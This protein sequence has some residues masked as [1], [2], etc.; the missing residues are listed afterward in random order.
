MPTLLWW[1]AGLACLLLFVAIVILVIRFNQ[2]SLARD[3]CTE[4]HRQLRA[5]IHERRSLIPSFLESCTTLVEENPQL[6][7][8]VDAV[9]DAFAAARQS[10]G[11]EAVGAAEEQLTVALAQLHQR[12]GEQQVAPG[13]SASDAEYVARAL[14]IQMCVVESRIAAGSRYYNANAVRYRSRR[15]GMMPVLMP[16]RFPEFTPVP[17]SE[18]DL[19]LDTDSQDI[20]P[21]SDLDYRPGRL[22]EGL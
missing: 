2:L 22:S 19:D 10:T 14:F 21:S 16:R 5:D 18:L 15:R 11:P 12:L 4:G 9:A 1:L 20:V 13:E 8:R 7:S 3:L 6:R 17:Y